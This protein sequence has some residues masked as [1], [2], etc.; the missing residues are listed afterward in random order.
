MFPCLSAP[1]SSTLSVLPLG[2]HTL[3]T[4]VTATCYFTISG[5]FRASF[6]IGGEE[7]AAAGGGEEGNEG[8]EGGQAQGSHLFDVERCWGEY[9]DEGCHVSRT[10]FPVRR[11]L[12]L[13]SA[14][15]DNPGFTAR[16]A[17]PLIFNEVE[18]S[19]DGLAVVKADP[20]L[21]SHEP[22][23]RY[24]Y[25]QFLKLK[26]ALEQHEGGLEQ[27]SRG[28]ETMGFTREKDAIVYREWAPAATAAQLVG[29]FNGW[30]GE[31]CWMER[32]HFGV[33]SVRLPDRVG[34]PAIA[35]GS[36]VK[37]RLQKGDGGWVE[38][39]P[40]WIKWATAEPGKMGA[41]YDGIYWDPPANEKYQFKCT[42]PPK[43]EA[44]RIY[45]AH[46]GMSSEE[47]RVAS[48]VEFANSVLPRIKA[49]GYNT[50]Q[51]MAVAE[52][53]YYASFGYH[54]T[55]FFAVSSR[56]GTPEDLKYLVDTAHSL[57]IRVFMDLI[58]SHASNNASDGLN[59]FD[60]GQSA[61]DSYFHTGERGYHKLWDSRCFNYS[62]W[63]VLRFL[64]SNLRYWLEEFQFDGFRFDGVTSMLYHHRGIGMSFSGDY[65]EYFSTSTDVD[66][67]VYLM[68]AN[69]L[70]HGVRPDATT[71]AEDVSGMPTL[72]LPVPIGGVGFDYR[73]AMAIPDRWIEYLKD[74]RDEE[75]SMRE[76]VH[77]LTNRR[78]TE[79]CVAYAESHDQ[80]MVGDK[81]FAF[82]LMDSDMYFHMSVL[83]KP[84]P[85]VERGVALHKMIHFITMALGG[86]GYLNFMGNEFGHPEWLD[87]PR[88]GNNW[89]YDRCRRMWHLRD[90]KLLRYQ[91]MNRFDQAMNALDEK[92]HF[93]AADHQIVS[94]ADGK[95]RVIVFERGDLLF[96]FN[97]HPTKTY[98]GYK[99]GCKEPG[100]WRVVLD[101]D[102]IEFGGQGR[103]G[104]DVDHFTSP[105]GIP[106]RPETNF[107]N[108]CC[109]LL[110]L[111]PSR[112][113]QLRKVLDTRTDSPELLAALG[114]LSGFYRENSL[115]NRRALKSTIERRGLAINEEFLHAS[116]AAQEALDVVEA[117]VRGL[118]ECCDR[119]GA[120]L[121]T[122]ASTTGDM[123]LAT[124][125]LKLELV[126]TVR[127]QQ[128]V[129]AFL[130]SYQLSPQ[131]VQALREDEISENFFEALNR[132][133][134]I[135]ANCKLLL[136]THHQRAGLELM[137][138]MA[139]Y[140]EGAYERLCRWVQAECR[141]LGDSDGDTP[142]VGPLL[143]T[144]AHCLKDRPV[145]FRY[146]TEEVANTRHNALFRRFIAALTR[147]GPG[148]MPRPIEVHAHDPLRYVGDML[149][150]LHQALAS[151]KELAAA[152]FA[153][154]DKPSSTSAESAPSGGGGSGEGGAR[155][156]GVD[157]DVAAVLDRVFEGVCR[158]FKVRVEQVLTGQPGLVLCY[159]LSSLLSFYCHTVAELLGEQAALCVVLRDLSEA[160][161]RA[162]L[163]AV[164]LRGDRVLRFPPA[165]PSDLSPPPLVG[166]GVA[167]VLELLQA[168][169]SM[170]VPAGAA[171]PDFLPV[172]AA[173]LDPLVEVCTRAAQA[174]TAKAVTALSSGSSSL[175]RR[176]SASA[177][178]SAAAGGDSGPLGRRGSVPLGR[179]ATDG[180][181]DGTDN[182]AVAVARHIFLANC[183]AA[184]HAPLVPF[185]VLTPYSQ[186]LA[187]ALSEHV[188]AMVQL[189]VA[190]ILDHCMLS[191]ILRLI[192]QINQASQQ[193]Q[194]QQEGG[195]VS[196]AGAANPPAQQYP[197]LAQFPEAS[198]SAVAESL[199]RLFALLAG[200]EG[201]LPEF[202]ALGVA[203]LRAQAAGLVAG[204]LAD[205]YAA[206]YDAVCDVRNQYPDAGGLLRHT[207]EHMRTILGI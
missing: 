83:E 137:D 163:D 87:F 57:G 188:T 14:P 156:G 90:D 95:D 84:T 151:E 121:T 148:G 164:K 43:P 123:V 140:Q 77:T 185:P 102:A 110:V 12:P 120:A 159:K 61:A 138:L 158:P 69:D 180:Q 181:D 131:E 114:V 124:E 52:H 96:V 51:L 168:H 191:P 165:V 182:T 2:L 132:V 45:E 150:W 67:V 70:I 26:R 78:Y 16:D 135:H 19:P 93:L 66:A 157:A 50:I 8:E 189:E 44:P 46:V 56:S 20:L 64:L 125:R 60:F 202:E 34:R 101:S 174:L 65:H 134:E 203:K 207:P 194:Q 39:I 199:Q 37:I 112:T 126:T 49:A 31:S 106:G 173:L 152:L 74:R 47:P 172:A 18:Y 108:R 58:H 197:P 129:A 23:L 127:R 149:A 98:E 119:I 54:V 99:V 4:K 63:E 205:A 145:L 15:G 53:S 85:A 81:S 147:G 22:H 136:R 139:V 160:A 198:P 170:M 40:A 80:S 32:N 35:H 206:V 92:Y 5:H 130:R 89:S 42:R 11:L 178:M 144:A 75:W 79:K 13:R 21:A 24:R 154:T 187:G 29:D 177:S 143:R 193:L 142:E 200:A 184:L 30:N 169:A 104:H 28:Y 3:L 62:N 201:R 196:A 48:Y 68:L 116:E 183:L 33:W 161:G 25:A 73:L 113:C 162:F 82:L 109:S 179:R 94:S 41:C 86:D 195:E 133:H 17:A 118:A 7:W 192:A 88:E 55:N 105:E 59:G 6:A 76:I 38:R 171:K 167:V 117:E 175:P 186:G 146:C 9:W 72:G 190:A 91:H 1:A 103:V 141:S 10:V 128:L 111:S 100:K 97:F 107:N 204:A 71:I 153:N 176:T 36:R 115:A 166:E 27:F 155:V 122:C